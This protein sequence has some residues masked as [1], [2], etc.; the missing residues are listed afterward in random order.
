MV[1]MWVAGWAYPITT[2][3]SGW[4]RCS[5]LTGLPQRNDSARTR[6][7][8]AGPLRRGC[9][10]V[11]NLTPRGRDVAVAQS[12][13][14][15]GG[16]QRALFQPGLRAPLDRANL[17]RPDASPP[18]RNIEGWRALNAQRNLPTCHHQVITK[19]MTASLPRHPIHRAPRDCRGRNCKC[20]SDRCKCSWTALRWS[21]WSRRAPEHPPGNTTG[22]SDAT[23]NETA[24]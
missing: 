14:E 18:F 2:A 19:G 15:G 9:H 6:P 12:S 16:R 23:L 20:T 17:F 24:H 13:P 10:A 8:P 7:A 1:A 5:T 22:E 4:G 3:G 11:L 21:R